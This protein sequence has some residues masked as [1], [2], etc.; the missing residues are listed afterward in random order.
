MGAAGAAVGVAAGA[1]A[2]SSDRMV[3]MVTKINN[4]LVFIT[5]LLTLIGETKHQYER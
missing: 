1:Q 4:A 3:T 2:D 5:F